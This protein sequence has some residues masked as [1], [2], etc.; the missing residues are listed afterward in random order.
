MRRSN[1][2]TS[3]G[4]VFFSNTQM[5]RNQWPFQKT[6]T[7]GPLIIMETL[8]DCIPRQVDITLSHKYEMLGAARIKPFVN[9]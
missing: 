2:K 3:L 5:F 1:S 8:Y 9:S 7:N 6:R 4:G